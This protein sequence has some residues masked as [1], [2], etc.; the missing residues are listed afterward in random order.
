MVFI[1]EY[2]A[3]YNYAYKFGFFAK[4]HPSYP[5]RLWSWLVLR[6]V[7]QANDFF[8][9]DALSASLKVTMIYF[10]GFYGGTSNILIQSNT[11]LEYALLAGVTPV[12]KA[13]WY[14]GLNNIEV[15]CFMLARR[16]TT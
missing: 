14:S 9:H 6:T 4:V 12:A 1:D 7:I 11:N 5:S 2:E 10:G 3:P 13:G 16:S 8:R 15:C